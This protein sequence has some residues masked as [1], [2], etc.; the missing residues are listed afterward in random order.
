MALD[1]AVGIVAV[2]ADIDDVYISKH[3]NL[4]ETSAFIRLTLEKKIYNVH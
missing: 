3:A 1:E 4:A 2:L